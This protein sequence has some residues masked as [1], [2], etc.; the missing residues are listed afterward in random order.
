MTPKSRRIFVL[1]DI[2]D[3]QEMFT[4]ILYGYDL[5]FFDSLEIA[6]QALAVRQY[7]LVIIDNLPFRPGDA[8][9]LIPHD[10]AYPVLFYSGFM[11]AQLAEIC[12]SKRIRWCSV[13]IAPRTLLAE[14]VRA[15]SPHCRF[16]R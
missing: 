1:L 14:V 4:R 5:E 12:Q 8:V 11:N 7:D 13:P 15:L 2:A 10:H 6:R 16:E 3:L 9:D